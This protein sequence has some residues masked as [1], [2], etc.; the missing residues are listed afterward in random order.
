MKEEDMAEIA[1]LIYLAITDFEKNKD[2]VMKR[3]SE[4]TKKYPLY[5]RLIIAPDINCRE[6]RNCFSALYF[7]LL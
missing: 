5:K 6:Q 2:L 4:L 7:S 3:V 1:D